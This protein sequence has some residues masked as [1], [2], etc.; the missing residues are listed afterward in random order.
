MDPETPE[1]VVFNPFDP[2]WRSDPYPFYKRLREEAPVGQ[3]P[4]IG[5]WY[6]SRFADCEAIL[7]SPRVGVDTRKS[8]FYRR[9]AESRTLR[10]PDELTERR[11]FLFL[12]P[13]DHT[14]LRGLVSSAFTPKMINSMRP[15]IQGHVDALLDAAEARGSLEIIDDLAYPLPFTV[16]AEMLGI[17]VADQGRFR[18]WSKQMAGAND[19]MLEPSPEVVE[20]QVTAVRESVAYLQA[21]IEGRRRQP[22]DDLISFLIAARQ[23][24]DKLSEDEL[25]SSI[26]LL[27]AAGHET[28]VN[29]ISNTVLALLRHPDQLAEVRVEPRLARAAVEETLR[30]DPPV[31]MTQRIALEDLEIGGAAIPRGAP[32]IVLVAAANRDEAVAPDGERFDLHRENIRHLTFSLGA[33]FCFGASLA[34]VEATVA[35]A[36]VVARFPKLRLAAE[37]GLRRR[38]DLVMRGLEVFPVEI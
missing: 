10:L 29:L 20:R 30:W 19:P 21:I 22:A 31:Q 28:T 16:I 4:F 34:R 18:A 27:V 38:S 33:H 13:P 37:D 23:E 7:T 15:R 17:P 2:E 1:P 25:I 9:L 11:S 12:D 14:R 5:I 36:A 6:L 8:D 35:T 32:V 3:V 26:T 24:G